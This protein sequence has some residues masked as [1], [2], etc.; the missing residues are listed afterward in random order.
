M[1]HGLSLNQSLQ[2]A[3][4]CGP[5][6]STVK[7]LR[8]SKGRLW[9]DSQFSPP[10]TENTKVLL[11]FALRTQHLLTGPCNDVTMSSFVVL[12]Y[13]PAYKSKEIHYSM[14]RLVGGKGGDIKRNGTRF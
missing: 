4:A 11:K 7:Y 2:G 10:V 9:R 5:K 12:K 14:R 8:R 13:E 1:I 6:T 3:N